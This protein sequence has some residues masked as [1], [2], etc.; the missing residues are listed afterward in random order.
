MAVSDWSTD[1]DLNV[2]ID[3][4]NIAEGCPPSNVNNALRAIMA[5]VKALKSTIEAGVASGYLSRSGGTV[6]GTLVLSRTT[7]ASGTADNGPALVVGGTRTQ[8]HI[9]VDGNELMA[10]GSG[11]TTAALYLNG[12]GGAVY[13]EGVRVAKGASK[14]GTARGVYSDSS[15]NLQPM[16]ATVGGTAKG[17]Y[18]K[19]G[20]V[21][22]MSA[23]IGGANQPV[24]MSGGTVKA[25]NNFATAIDAKSMV[26]GNSTANRNANTTYTAAKNGWLRVWGSYS[27]TIAGRRYKNT[28]WSYTSHQYK[29]NIYP[30]AKGQS[31]RCSIASQWIDAV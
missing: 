23:S 11:T 28:F 24:Y 15:G 22:A 25:C 3:G 27:L 5:N 10:K 18:L 1:A 2:S 30:V 19:N 31:Y 8:A 7:D 14:G 29:E 9:E 17:V 12:D 20:T 16:S 26:P 6:T 4:I 13:A 21:T